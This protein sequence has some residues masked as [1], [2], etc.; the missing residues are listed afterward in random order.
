MLTCYHSCHSSLV[1]SNNALWK[2]TLYNLK[3]YQFDILGISRITVVC[4]P[5]IIHYHLN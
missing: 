2:A 5:I 1:I 4:S 3:M